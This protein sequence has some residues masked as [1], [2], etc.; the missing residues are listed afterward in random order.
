MLFNPLP[1]VSRLNELF[2]YEQDTGLLRRRKP[3]K[4]RVAFGCCSMSTSGHYQVYVDGKLYA[5][6]RV[7][8]AIATGEA[9]PEDMDIDHANR[10][11]TD[12][13]WGNLRLATRSQ[14]ATNIAPRGRVG[15]KGVSLVRGR[16][17]ASITVGNKTRH[18]GYFSS[19]EDASAAYKS[20]A[21]HSLLPMVF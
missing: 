15:A 9:P 3:R 12:N 17:R 4:N 1:S 11:K 14:N 6:H 8:W 5:A 21:E 10:I 18:I 2:V 20:A 19:A 16:F 13:R 7:V